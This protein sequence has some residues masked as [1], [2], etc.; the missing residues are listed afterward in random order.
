MERHEDVNIPP[1]NDPSRGAASSAEL[2]SLIRVLTVTVD[3]I[4]TVTT[5]PLPAKHRKPAEDEPEHDFDSEEEGR[6][7]ETAWKTSMFKV[8]EETKSLLQT[9][10]SLPRL[11]NN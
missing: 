3:K 6:E 9:C 11:A 8:S 5:N 4:T 1:K 10:F 7:T 2:A